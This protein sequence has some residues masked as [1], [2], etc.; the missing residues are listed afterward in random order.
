MAWA[1]F[2]VESSKRA[3]LDTVLR[4]DILARQSQKLRDAATL[5]GKPG[6]LYVL[7]E[8]S[9]E[10]VRRAE[11]MLA[12]V[13]RHLPPAEAD[14]ILAKL[15]DEEDSASAGMGLFFTE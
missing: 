5:G 4:D 7:I 15:R 8:G 2:D 9:E 14:P 10:A 13:G 11:T 3:D 1:L 6:Q 12:P